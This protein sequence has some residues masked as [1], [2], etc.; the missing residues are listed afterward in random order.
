MRRFSFARCAM[1]GYSAR[2]DFSLIQAD[3]GWM[4][5]KYFCASSARPNDVIE[6]CCINIY[7]L[8]RYKGTKFLADNQILGTLN[9]TQI[10]QITQIVQHKC[11]ACAEKICEI[12]VI[13]VTKRM[14]ISEKRE[15]WQHG[16]SALFPIF[17]F[18]H[19]AIKTAIIVTK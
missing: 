3:C 12:C 13:C 1:S 2:S 8:R 4:K 16:L 15:G 17:E 10:S 19:I 7:V 18:W 6:F 14:I 9:F 11:C 5:G